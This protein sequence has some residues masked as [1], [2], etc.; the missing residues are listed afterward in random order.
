M[1]VISTVS[2]QWASRPNDERY[3]SLA[4]LFGAV[5]KRRQASAC[6][7][8]ATEHLSVIAPD[9]SMELEL[10]DAAR[11][12]HLG[13]LNHWSFGQLCA[14]A[15]ASAS[16]LRKLPS[17][18]AAPCLEWNLSNDAERS[19]AKVLTR[20]DGQLTASV[21]SPTYGR[22]WDA[23][24]VSAV[25]SR[26]GP[27]WKV[28]AASYASSNPKLA[29]TLY[30]SDRDVFLF[31]VNEERP[32]EVGNESLFRGIYLW[33]SE[34]G[35]ATFGMATMLYR[36]V[37]DNRNIWGP[38]DFREIRVRHTSGGPARFMAQ[39]VP[40]LRAYAD[41]STHETVKAINAAQNREVGRDPKSVRDWLTSKGFTKSLSD[42]AQANAESSGLNPRSIWGLVQGLTD[43]AHR[44]GHTNDRVD[45]ERKAGALLDL[46]A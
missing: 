37:C 24:V 26:L 11:G 33:N 42:R 7:D 20:D 38:A 17:A 23:E 32:I 45:L 30:A 29:S 9:D 3:L 25:M 14:A 13:A 15:G 6:Y 46:A 27:E 35:S 41:A 43:E 12:R 39:A 22:I 19:D 36:F 16:Y 4:D 21:Q 40:Q 8:I 10:V 1:D 5:S 28:P 18:L 34:V 2:Q 31:L 44:I